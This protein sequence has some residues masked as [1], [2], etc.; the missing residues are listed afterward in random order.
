MKGRR[1]QF[2]KLFTNQ[3]DMKLSHKANGTNLDEM[4]FIR[5]A[6]VFLVPNDRDDP[7][8]DLLRVGQ[9]PGPVVFIIKHLWTRRKRKYRKRVWRHNTELPFCLIVFCLLFTGIP[10][11]QISFLNMI[12]ARNKTMDHRADRQGAIGKSW[13]TTKESICQRALPRASGSNL[14]LW[15]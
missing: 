13:V 8:L 2:G 14:F 7:F 9:E 3:A 6:M 15:G 5:A 10:S 12:E 11:L 1:F 4:V